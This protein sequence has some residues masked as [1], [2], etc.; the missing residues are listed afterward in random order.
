MKATRLVAGVVMGLGLG[1]AAAQ[2]QTVFKIGWT[3]TID[4]HYGVGV[5]TFGEEIAKRTNGRYKL[6]YVPSGALGGEREMLEA[7]QLGTQDMIITSTGPVG[8]FVPET[9]IVDIPYL[10]R[11]YDHARKVL[12]GPIGQDMLAKFDD[13]GLHALGWGEQGFRHITNS[14]GPIA[15][16]ADLDGLKIRTMENPV[17]LEAFTALGAAPT[18]MAWPEVIPALEQGAIDGQENP[19]SV[20]VSAKLGEV[21]KYLSLDGHVYSPAIV[22]VSQKL[23]DSL[24]DTQKAAFEKAGDAAVVAMRGYVDNVEAQGVETLK[25]QGMQVNTLTPEDKQAFQDKLADVYVD[26]QNQ[27][28][29]ELMDSIIASK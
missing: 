29:K 22:M 27:F 10:F 9:R 25:A 21:Q 11:D 23:W 18:P 3:N 26:Y 6:Q 15:K 19:L 13:V 16:P 20:I 12:D 5:T 8:N 7:V 1:I 14:R 24:D 17:H 2:A 4:S 28:G